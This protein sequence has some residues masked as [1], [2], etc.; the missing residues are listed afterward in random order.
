MKDHPAPDRQDRFN[1]IAAGDFSGVAYHFAAALQRERKIP[2]G[3][4]GNAEN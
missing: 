2:V 4:I 1:G 3:V